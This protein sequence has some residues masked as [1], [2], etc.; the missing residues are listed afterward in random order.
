MVLLTLGLTVS[1]KSLFKWSLGEFKHRV[2]LAASSNELERNQEEG[3]TD[4]EWTVPHRLVCLNTQSPSVGIVWKGIEPFVSG[5][6][7]EELC[8]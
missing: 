7:L 2:M 6:S 8:L 1:V 4:V 5:G 3:V